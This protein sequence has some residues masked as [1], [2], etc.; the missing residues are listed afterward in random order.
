MKEELVE[1]FGEIFSGGRYSEDAYI[2]CVMMAA[3][4]GNTY[5]ENIRIPGLPNADSVHRKI[6]AVGSW[7]NLRFYY[8]R[9]VKANMEKLVKESEYYVIID[10][11]PWAYYGRNFNDNIY[12]WGYRKERGSTASF[13]FL[14]A[15]I[16]LDNGYK[17]Y[18]DCLPVRRIGYF[19]EE[20]VY[21]LLKEII[22][23]FGGRLPKFVL[24]DRGFFS[25][26]VIEKLEELGVK[27]VIHARKTPKIKNTISKCD[28]P[29]AKFDY[30]L[31]N[32]VLTT[33]YI[34]RCSNSNIT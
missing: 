9:Y 12:L 16:V 25:H 27:Y 14:S 5:L 17:F 24:L 1:A 7:E 2:S 26:K 34:H 19:R 13:L 29:N 20:A 28:N 15:L 11:T 21:S 32:E 8:K 31:N 18:F 10:E 3:G 6:K 30:N 23:W 4:M 22:E 33:L